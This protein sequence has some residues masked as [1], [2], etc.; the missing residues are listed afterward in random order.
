MRK[1]LNLEEI[2]EMLGGEMQ[3]GK[4]IL[5]LK[6]V[7]YYGDNEMLELEFEGGS[8]EVNAYW[9]PEKVYV[10]LEVKIRNDEYYKIREELVNLR[11]EKI[12]L[13]RQGYNTSDIDRKIKDLVE[14][15]RKFDLME[16][17]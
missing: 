13:K 4:C 5:A 16:G 10:P 12:R 3:R 2:C 9:S 1:R 15:L 6:D 17:Q 11:R 7:T 8:L 14:R